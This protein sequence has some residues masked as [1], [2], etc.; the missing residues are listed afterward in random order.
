MDKQAAIKIIRDTFES[1]FDKGR[2]ASFAR[3]LLNHLDESSNFTLGGNRLPNA[4]AYQPYINSIE[5]IGKYE[6]TENNKIDI[7]IVRLKKETSLEYARTMQRNFVARYLNGSMGGELKDAALVAFVSPGDKDW[8][9]S[10]VKMDY[11]LEESPAGKTKIKTE[12]TPA[13][14]W[15]FL[16]GENESSHTAQ[17]QLLPILQNDK[18]NPLLSDIEKAFSIEVV[19]KEFFAKYRD[20]FLEVKETLENIISKDEKIRSDFADK[21]V[22]AV[23]FSKKLLGQI[24]FLYFLQKKGWFGVER[25]RNWGTGPRNFLRLLFKQKVFAMRTSSTIFSNHCSMK[26]WLWKELAIF[27]NT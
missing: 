4:G 1:S 19:T 24:V 16:V 6:D 8:R 7:L 26:R 20:L 11:R 21:E 12:L 13:H 17:A 3:N 14:R 2:F 27:T 25:D 10:L 5:R 18:N 15:S 23:D 22:N 9:F